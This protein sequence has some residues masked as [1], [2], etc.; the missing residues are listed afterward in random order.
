MIKLFK[1]LP[2]LVLLLTAALAALFRFPTGS[3][4]ILPAA[5]WAGE[6]M[7]PNLRLASVEGSLYQGYE[8]RGLELVSG[9]D[10]YL[11]LGRAA[12][13][14]DWGLILSGNPWVRSLE[15]ESFSSDVNHLQALAQHFA[16]SEDKEEPSSPLVVHPLRVS[17]RD[18]NLAS[19]QAKLA[20]DHLKLT[21]EGDLSLMAQADDLPLA[22]EGKLNFD[23]LEL[24]SS[25]L[26]LGEGRGSLKGKL[27]PP[28]DLCGD[29]TALPLS[30]LLAFVPDNTIRASGRLDGRFQLKGLSDDLTASGVLALPNSVVMDVPLSLRVPWGWSDGI[31]AVS[32]ATMKTAAADVNLDAALDLSHGADALRLTARGNAQ[33]ISL[34][35]IGRIA[36]PQAGLAGEGGRVSFDVRW[37]GG[38]GSATPGGALTGDFMARLPEVS[39]AGKQVVRA[40][41]AD[42]RMSPGEA[43]KI[44]CGGQVFGGKLF[45]RGEVAH[46]DGRV[47]PQMIFS[48]VNVDLAA[49]AAALPALKEAKPSGKVSVT[50][51]VSE[52]MSAGGKV[53]SDRLSASGVTISKLAADVRWRDGLAVLDSLTALLGKAPVTASGS[54]NVKAQTLAFKAAVRSFDPKSI[55]QIAGQFSGLCDADAEVGGT[56]ANPHAS[57]H[58]RGRNNRVADVPLGNLNLSA[59]YANNRLTIPQTRLNLPGGAVSFR[60]DVALPPGGDPRLDIAASSAGLDLGQ[61][62]KVLKLSQPVTGTVKGD[63]SV[64]GPLRTATVKAGLRAD[65][66]KTG[67]VDIPYAV[68]EAN[69]SM[70]Q[71]NVEK[72]EAGVGTAVIRGSG[73]LKAGK[74]SLLDSA[75]NIALNVKGLALRPL[76][77]RFMGSAPVGGVL[78]GA[79]SFRGTLANPALIL[80]VDSPLSVSQMIIDSMALTLTS[81]TANRYALSASGRMG[82]FKLDLDGDVKKTD[83]GWDYTV[84]TKPVDVGA[85]LAAQSPEMKGMVSGTATVAVK[86]SAPGDSPIDIQVSSKKLTAIDKVAITDISLPVKVLLKSDKIQMKEGRAT[87]SKG[88]IKTVLD[89]DLKKSKWTGKVTVRGLDFGN[90]AAPFMPEGELVGSTDVDVDLKGN[91]GVLATTFA[92]GRFT[93][94]GGYL[95]KMAMI[96]KITPTKRISFENIRGTFFWDGS[97]LFL[98]PGTQATAGPE[99]PL[100]RYFSIDGAAGIPGHG[101]KLFCKGRFDLKMLDQILGAM[102]GVFQYMTGGLTDSGTVVRDALGRAIGLKSRDFQD[103]SFTLANS[104]QNLRLLNLKIDKP[105]KDFLPLDALNNEEKQ[106]DDKQFKL[107]LKFPTGP[108]S[109]SPEDEST[110]DQ[111][112]EQILDNLLNIG[113]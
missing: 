105:L 80:R 98:N 92:T 65:K 67:E 14:P 77:T 56:F 58:V 91:M 74:K 2:V 76:L 97:D 9:D 33:N 44:S 27:L 50:L 45:G 57:V 51:K 111:L 17:V 39:A 41:T 108:G 52:D 38:S 23:P 89:V 5:R 35:E 60:G 86:G 20:L 37:E 88:A 40:L 68:L 84:T 61:L 82:D 104:W 102:K 26:R 55:P 93:T 78:D 19:P 47:L 36:A 71:V 112:K 6:R 99:E 34:R 25:D 59:S 75:L 90:L 43:P 24:L 79:L 100:Y 83:K 95:H 32:G 16:S 18:V 54:A 87:L 53:T 31:F 110:E 72:L 30:T 22:L 63:V 8:V 46:T 96:N 48:L 73:S 15:L 21:P 64:R 1:F 106:K 28:F 49:V 107:N 62:S 42:V 101:L 12:V 11:T 13:S 29:L 113:G 94:S 70:A 109:G 69:G 103:V 85:L 66:V 81:P 7:T 4:L 3:W 10:T